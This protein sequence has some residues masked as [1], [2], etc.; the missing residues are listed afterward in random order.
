MKMSVKKEIPMKTPSNNMRN[1]YEEKRQ[2]TLSLIQ[3]AINDIKEDHRIVTKKELMELTGLSSGTF[4][5]EYVKD[6]LA[7]NQVCQFKTSK[8]ISQEKQEKNQSRIIAELSSEN[9][10]LSSQVQSLKI[11]LE[12]EVSAKKK[13]SLE[14]EALRNENALLKGKY[15]QL[16]EYLEVLGADLSKLPLV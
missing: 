8:A 6:L 11:A 13:Q 9:T 10:R 1:M 5:Q 12:K 2:R 14:N 16:L 15:Q 4:S 3:N 7:K